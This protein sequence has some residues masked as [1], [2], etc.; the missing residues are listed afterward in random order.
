MADKKDLY[1]VLGINKNATKDDIKTAYRRLAKKYHPDNKETGNEAKFK[2]VQEAYDIL[3]DDQNV[4]PTT[5]SATLLLIK[6]ALIQALILLVDLIVLV[7]ILL[8]RKELI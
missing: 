7:E 8:V 4:P 1:E 6:L 5:N 2:E 3:F